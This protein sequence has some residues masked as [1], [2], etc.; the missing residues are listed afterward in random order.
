MLFRE[1]LIKGNMPTYILEGRDIQYWIQYIDS[2][3]AEEK[4]EPQTQP[5][6]KFSVFRRIALH[7]LRV[8]PPR[9]REMAACSW[10]ILPNAQAEGRGC[11]AQSV[12]KHDL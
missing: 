4:T 3:T 8:V 12:R 10:F 6:P 7:V 11:L 9:F 1:E 5:K 2:Q